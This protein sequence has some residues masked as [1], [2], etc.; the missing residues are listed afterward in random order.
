MSR[1][2]WSSFAVAALGL[3]LPV[4]AH[5]AGTGA[6]QPG[7]E[8][9][10]K[11]CL[12]YKQAELEADVIVELARAADGKWVGTLDLPN[13]RIQFHPLSNI[14]VEGSA[15]TFDFNRFAQKAQVMVETPY[16]GTLSADGN[17]ITG[18]FFEGKKSHRALTLTRI[19]APGSE[20]PEPRMADLRPLSDSSEEL[21]ALFNRDAGK[22]RLLILLSPT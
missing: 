5:A 14:K 18:D 10:W 15:V 7:A 9:L 6:A 12:I 8:G 3:I 13:Q 17:T 16:T 20:R 21:R 4:W 1:R 11:G 22:T 2:T 19:G